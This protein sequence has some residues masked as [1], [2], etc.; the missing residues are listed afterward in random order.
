MQKS[1]ILTWLAVLCIALTGC[2]TSPSST[3]Y[4]LDSANTAQLNMLPANNVSIG[5]GPVA[6]PDR[7]DRSQLV[8][9]SGKNTITI[10]EYD[11]WGDSFKK[12]VVGTLAE[13]LSILLNTSQVVVFPW[14]RALRPTYQVFVTVRHFEGGVGEAVNLEADW[15][16]VDVASEETLLTSQYS[17]RHPVH[18]NDLSSYVATQSIALADLSSQIALGICSLAN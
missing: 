17:K 6:I 9:K 16:V 4:V 5:V 11:R 12:Q 8:T 2:G 1:T 7:F 13:D 15:R 10:H 3:F 14:E 18:G